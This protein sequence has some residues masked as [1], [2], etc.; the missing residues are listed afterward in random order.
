MRT[1]LD[2][3][4][5]CVRCGSVYIYHPTPR[6]DERLLN[7]PK[8][9]P[10]CKQLIVDALR[11]VPRLFEGR[12]RDVRE[13]PEF[14]GIGLGDVIAWE[15]E[16]LRPKNDGRLVM[17]R[18]WPALVDVENNDNQHIRL[19]PGHTYPYR[20]IGFRVS[21]WQKRSD[22]LIEVNMEFDLQKGEFTGLRW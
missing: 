11:D 8:H 9:C 13:V 16:F 7:D 12:W 4:K 19:V 1:C 3:R 6:D 10:R 22:Y 15:K 18:I 20:G 5:R 21:T 2:E 14:A 17:Q